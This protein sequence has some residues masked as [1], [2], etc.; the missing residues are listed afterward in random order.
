ME[1][2]KDLYFVAIK[3]FLKDKENNFLI[4]KDKWGSW[5][6]PGGRLRE[7]DFDASFSD[8]IKRKIFEELGDKIE[9]LIGEPVVYMRHERDEHLP[10]GETAKRRIFAIGYEAEYLG[11][12]IQLGK[13]HE[14]F[15]WVNI[16]D[17]NPDDY[18][19]GGWL[20]GVSEYL[21]RYRGK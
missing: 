5:D 4:T 15:E 18:F 13:S 20:K 11:G 2:D 16:N 7:I 8:I 10:N 12:E 21:A 3:V 1:H 17:F 9:Y 19:T 6:L 14:K